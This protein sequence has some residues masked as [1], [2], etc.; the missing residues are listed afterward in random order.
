MEGRVNRPPRWL[1]A[2]YLSYTGHAAR[3]RPSS[4]SHIYK[5]PRPHG[6]LGT[7][8]SVQFLSGALGRSVS[9][10][11]PASLSGNVLSLWQSSLK[12]RATG[13][14]KPVVVCRVLPRTPPRFVRIGWRLT[15]TDA[16]TRHQ[17]VAFVLRIIPSIHKETRLRPALLCVF[18]PMVFG[19]F[20]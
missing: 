16:S 6:F 1:A 11:D 14:G 2:L 7:I 18:R 4:S 17:L 10:T 9:C 3:L 15:K 13:P 19:H 5:P 8:H 20:G 12:P